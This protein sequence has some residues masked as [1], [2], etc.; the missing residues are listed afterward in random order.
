MLRRGLSIL[1]CSCMLAG[2]LPQI[3][4]A[5]EDAQVSKTETELTTEKE[6]T[7]TAEETERTETLGQ[8]TTVEKEESLTETGREETGSVQ[9]TEN[10]SQT[11]TI[12]E[13]TSQTETTE[14]ETARTELSEEETTKNEE[15]EDTET[16]IEETE[17]TGTT[18]E[19]TTETVTESE[20]SSQLHMAEANTDF[21]IWDISASYGS[22]SF[23]YEVLNT[24]E[25][26]YIN[27]EAVNGDADESWDWTS[28]ESGEIRLPSDK[29][30]YVIEGL[31][32]STQYRIWISQYGT[33]LGN[34]YE[35]LV[36]TDKCPYEVEYQLEPRYGN[37][38]GIIATV[39]S[40]TKEKLPE[41]FQVA[42]KFYDE[43]GSPCSCGTQSSG[44]YGDEVIEELPY[45]KEC[46][47]SDTHVYS[48]KTYKIKVW[49]EE[50][51]MYPYS[52]LAAQTFDVK[53]NA[54]GF[55]ASDVKVD[56]AQDTNNISNANVKVIINNIKDYT[57]LGVKMEYREKNSG[58][59]WGPYP[60][61]TG[62]WI[63]MDG[64]ETGISE[65]NIGPLNSGTVYEYILNVDGTKIEGEFDFGTSSTKRDITH[66]ANI[67][68]AAITYKLDAVSLSSN[69]VYKITPYYRK[70]NENKFFNQ[71]STY[72]LTADNDYRAD[73]VLR[74]LEEDTEYDIKLQLQE[75]KS[76][77]ATKYYA[78]Y[79]TIKTLTDDRYLEVTEA[80]PLINGMKLNV[81]LKGTNVGETSNQAYLF[82]KEKDA[83]EDKAWEVYG[84]GFGDE[85]TETVY[86][87]EYDNKALKPDTVYAYKAG[88]AP[89]SNA[90]KIEDLKNVNEGEFKTAVDNRK[91]TANS[92]VAKAR[93]AEF[94]VNL[95]GNLAYHNRIYLY[96]REKG[97]TGEWIKSDGGGQILGWW[98]DNQ[99]IVLTAQW[100]IHDD[101]WEELKDGTEYEY[102][103][104]IGL[105]WESTYWYGEEDI[106][107]TEEGTFTT[108]EDS[109]ELSD[110][111]ITSGYSHA[112]VETVLTGNAFGD[113]T[114]PCFYYKKQG[115][116][117]W[118]AWEYEGTESYEKKFK[119]IITDL[120]PA[121]TYDYVLTTYYEEP[122]NLDKL[123]DF[124]KKIG[125]FATKKAD[126]QLFF[127]VNE[128]KSTPRKEVLKVSASGTAKDAL[129]DIHF[130]LNNGQTQEIRLTEKSGY[131]SEVIFDQL[132]AD[133]KY[134]IE[135]ADIY[136]TERI[137]YAEGTEDE[138][139]ETYTIHILSLTPKYE[140][141]TKEAITPESI[142]L[143]KTELKYTLYNE[144]DYLK[145]T[146]S[147][148][149]AS[150]DV[151]WS[152]SNADVAEVDTDGY[153]YP[154]GEGEA[155]ITA[156][157]IYDPEVKASAKVSVKNYAVILTDENK[158]VYSISV[159]KGSIATNITYAEMKA[160]TDKWEA[161][162]DITAVS[163][164][165]S[166][167]E[168]KA[169]DNGIYGMAGNSVGDATV[170][171]DKDGYKASI[172]VSV[173]TQASGFGI[174]GLRASSENYPALL[175]GENTYQI[176]WHQDLNI[177]YTAQITV[178]PAAYYISNNDFVWTSSNEKA[179]TV[180]SGQI[181]PTGVGTTTIT[182][183]PSADKMEIAKLPT[184]DFSLEVK[185]LPATQIQTAYAV[186]NVDKVLGDVR[187]EN[188]E[189]WTW[190]NP[191]T[192]LYSLPVN[193]DYYAFEASYTGDRYYAYEGMVNVYISTVTGVSIEEREA[194]HRN[195]IM[196]GG[197]D[198]IKLQVSPS[199]TGLLP[200]SKYTI[201]IP[202]I[203][204]IT[205]TEGSEKGVYTIT[206]SKTGSY[207]LKPEI[208]IG[209]KIVTTGSYKIKAV[210]DS[211]V[212][213][214]ELRTDSNVAVKDGVI[215]LD[216]GSGVENISLTA[217]A[218]NRDGSEN[219][220]TKLKW[221][222][223]D[224][225]VAELT[226]S[227]DRNATVQIKGS[228][229]AMIQVRAADLT[230]VSV[231]YALEMRDYSPR[232]EGSK[233]TINTA[234]D[235][236]NDDE[237]SLITASQY[238]F[239]EII[240]VYSGSIS[241]VQIVS[242]N[243]TKENLDIESDFEAYNINGCKY[244]VKPKNPDMATGKKAVQLAVTTSAGTVYLYPLT[245]TIINKQPKVQFKITKAMN[246]FYL[247]EKGRA[248]VTLENNNFFTIE[249]FHWE[250]GTDA[251]GFTFKRN[252]DA[253]DSRKPNVKVYDISGHKVKMTNGILADSSVADGTV[254]IKLYGVR[255][256]YTL[257]N[258]T[259]KYSYKKPV[260]KT[261]DKVT[262]K[263]IS[264]IIPSM[265]SD[266]I[267]FRIVDNLTKRSL[268]YCEE[269]DSEYDDSEK[270][271]Y[272]KL[273]CDDAGIRLMDREY[274][275]DGYFTGVSY[276]GSE[277]A[278][279][280][281]MTVDS[282]NWREALMVNHKIKTIAPRAVLSVQKL[283]FN[284]NYA[285]AADVGISLKDYGGFVS[286][287]DIAVEG[288]DAKA[289][290]LLEDDR[291]QVVHCEGDGYVGI[292]LNK[293]RYMQGQVPKGTYTYKLT[294]YYKNPSTGE[295]TA[296]NTVLLKINFTDK[297]ITAKASGKGKL[298][299]AMAATDMKTNSVA[300]T[301]RFAGTGS[302][303]RVKNA[304]ITG[305][306]NKYFEINTDQYSDNPVYFIKVSD[307]QKG[308]LKAGTNYNLS[309]IYTLQSSGG[310]EF[311]V[312]SNVLRVKPVQKAPKITV[313]ENNFI[314]YAAADE[315]T[316]S[317]MIYTPYYKS[318][319]ARD[320]YV[321]EDA[322]GSIDVN[323]DGM[324]DIEVTMNDR[325]SGSN[326]YLTIRIT[327]KYAVTASP[328]GKQYTIPV[329]VKVTGRDGI[330]KDASV[331]IK[332]KVK[333]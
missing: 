31:T 91:V 70:H 205:V 20:E 43:N 97:T 151:T 46:T 297:Q 236:A 184:V 133:T 159:N 37:G 200:E 139:E 126:Y 311:T 62:S 212:S 255:K 48:N 23:K 280:V 233:L 185:E 92:V 188:W 187:L 285:N 102:K 294:P 19:E 78:D 239:V 44:R 11:E 74:G 324:A 318:H 125:T 186:T 309:L 313:S 147:P 249:S 18:E 143:D 67:L 314:L 61:G 79:I 300:V 60:Y 54:S 191:Q 246:M 316:R 173:Y 229:H 278:L 296:L 114:G 27:W 15:S 238:G 326:A 4:F 30:E 333:R 237:G 110:P 164:K 22:I 155:V 39:K 142:S 325:D 215:C 218:Y 33:S 66:T 170:T 201:K 90:P 165:P 261:V 234:Y 63:T 7:E 13:E 130:V 265:G 89:Y 254:T 248:A 272:N 322:Y 269:T 94:N 315:V 174:T 9:E 176:A 277:N 152:T 295:N 71:Y 28:V 29:D 263:D 112:T 243:A 260:L 190:K 80:D 153:V 3:G 193:S 128:A 167:A 99:P 259:V 129:L 204:G 210:V 328:K 275:E 252:E 136:V 124:K 116:S 329:T 144:G 168:W 290:E 302:G 235:Y 284:T 76:G 250:D 307:S 65:I 226:T 73:I 227:D 195:I 163:A 45:R 293:L 5:A 242:Q 115:S 121:T 118:Q 178:S 175:K 180:Q 132:N 276:S 172:N 232:V 84:W 56:V 304:V 2:S 85:Y 219:T 106:R 209:D 1:L 283:T 273:Q 224:K 104:G 199:Y 107:F 166:V 47:A 220:T 35:K 131:K 82:Y 179:A 206:A 258:I 145:V 253:E 194:D 202:V 16:S 241:R 286:F 268:Y 230:G 245:V 330:S 83:G 6:A 287:A 214:I 305:D 171:F 119:S 217:K 223:T 53:T 203:E 288:A 256:A 10:T 64:D 216:T 221:S 149:S 211:Q 100:L 182:V 327:D 225:A 32:P 101:Y 138:W 332:V 317:C 93:C 50:W 192:Q 160:G 95:T 40:S 320:Y 150:N 291:L 14:E 264:N 109:R 69:A 270:D 181:T 177:V 274:M 87:S 141:T 86:L 52:K 244:I 298:D 72:D 213:R 319:N 135:R 162:T 321:I 196:A 75:I 301:A 303:Y 266:K 103:I 289:A 134:T 17:Q 156:T 117:E 21:R 123:P 25:N 240:P 282:D 51:N 26:Y 105:H 96:L 208:K 146:A 137:C 113:Y 55:S 271:Y 42:W 158:P 189:G 57:P 222:V 59:T 299:L 108:K 111:Q 310:D 8:E 148:A 98:N 257:E 251:S 308:R 247:T 81:T 207:I 88:F 157:S 267:V 36:T 127:E 38:I 77:G 231:G 262:K 312:Q 281:S 120:S 154:C 68:D 306:Y 140:F 183:K 34:E 228:G 292:R 197:S 331:V 49:L 169:A 58:D 279:C 323:K 122:E 41:C 24:Y 161:L 12:R 198:A